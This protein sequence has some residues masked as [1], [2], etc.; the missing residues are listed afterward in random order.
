MPPYICVSIYSCY[1]HLEHRASVKH[2]V[3]LEVP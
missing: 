3:L 1:S 2:F